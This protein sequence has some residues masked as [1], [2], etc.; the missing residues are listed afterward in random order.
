MR[1]ILTAWLS[2]LIEEEVTS[3]AP[4]GL[5]DDATAE[6]FAESH[7]P[8]Q[9]Q[10]DRAASLDF[11]Q[12]Q[13]G[14]QWAI[15]CSMGGMTGRRNSTDIS[16]T[17][18]E[19]VAVLLVRRGRQHFSQRGL[20]AEVTS[21]T[22]LLWD[23]VRP[24]ESHVPAALVKTTMFMPRDR[25]GALLPGFERLC[26]RTL[27]DSPAL[28]LLFGWMDTAVRHGDADTTTAETAGRVAADLLAVA[29]GSEPALALDRHE[30]L[31][32]Q[33][34]AYINERLADPQLDT[35]TIAAATA[36]STRY[37][38]ELFRRVDDTPRHYLLRQRLDR[39]EK[40]LPDLLLSI[41]EIA[42]RCGFEHPSSFSRAYRAAFGRSPR[43]A[44]AALGS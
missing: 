42:Y 10:I 7:L 17:K 11:R 34:K 27:P 5:V 36:V 22:A 1:V 4:H 2:A 20:T 25:C 14:D 12:A 37:L 23:S 43:E 31:L 19:Y 18:G 21:G 15:N 6:R 33:V 40:L 26:T 30:V 39:A 16:R 32:M 8:W 13:F 29:V 9:L 44:R 38:H 3:V 28:R 41:T 24:A 35:A